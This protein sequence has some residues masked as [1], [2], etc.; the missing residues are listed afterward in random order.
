MIPLSMLF[1]YY[2]TFGPRFDYETVFSRWTGVSHAVLNGARPKVYTPMLIEQLLKLFPVVNLFPREFSFNYRAT[3]YNAV[4]LHL[5]IVSQR[6][7]HQIGPEA[8]RHYRWYHT[9]VF[10]CTFPL[11]SKPFQAPPTHKWY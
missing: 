8:M 1:L 10:P 5:R 9:P 7:S 4:E 11:P 6:F 2:K 3:E